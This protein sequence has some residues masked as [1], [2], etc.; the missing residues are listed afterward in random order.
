VFPPA[1]QHL[2]LIGGNSATDFAIEYVNPLLS[3]STLMW[4]IKT[5]TIV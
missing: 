3:V 2:L 1:S 5:P 4:Y